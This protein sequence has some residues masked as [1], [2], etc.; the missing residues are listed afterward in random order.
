[1]TAKRAFS[2]IELLVA[3]SIGVVL[4]AL[5]YKTM[6]PMMDRSNVVSEMTK[7]KAMINRAKA[8]AM[9]TSAPVR[10]DLS[11]GTMLVL[12]DLD[13]SGNFGKDANGNDDLRELVL[14]ENLNTGVGF[15]G[16]K[17]HVHFVRVGD[18]EL[19]PGPIPHPSG[20]YNIDPDDLLG[21]TTFEDDSFLIT[22]GIDPVRQSALFPRKWQLFLQ[23]QR[24]FSLYLDSYYRSW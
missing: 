18:S 5:A 24:R 12:V 2:L 6:R 1:M 21:Y 16:A 23:N 11:A 8:K 3:V 22:P 15:S 17:D 10:V 19:P 13:R 14:G 9:E 4:S 7:F 20:A